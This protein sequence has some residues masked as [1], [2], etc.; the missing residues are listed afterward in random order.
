[1]GHEEMLRI[2]DLDTTID[3]ERVWLFYG[4]GDEWVGS[5]R[6]VVMRACSGKGDRVVL[7]EDV[8]HAFCI[9]ACILFI[10]TF[11]RACEG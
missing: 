6:E 1:M 3:W 5:E 8:P 9:R 11:R 2:R 4:G 10:F 7:D